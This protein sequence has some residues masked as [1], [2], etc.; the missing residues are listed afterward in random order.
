VLDKSRL[1]KDTH[2]IGLMKRAATI[3]AHAHARAMRFAKPGAWEHEVEAE[4]LHEFRKHGSEYPAYTSIVATGANA[5][6]LHYISNNAQLQDGDLMLIDAGCELGGYASD[7][8]RCF[9]VNGKFSGPQRDLYELVLAA[10]AAAIAKT[11]PGIAYDVPHEAAVKVLAR[12]M[13]DLK[14]LRGSLDSVLKL[15]D[16][17][18][19]SYRRFYM[20]R[21]GHWL[22]MDVHDAGAY[23]TGDKWNKLEVGN[24]VTIEPGIYV[25]PAA[26]VPKA[27]WNIGIRIEDD[28]LLVPGGNTLITHQA[29]KTIQAIEEVMRSGR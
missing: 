16:K 29:P 10:Q 13:L 21:T 18:E 27:F 3:S 9:P 17:G 5:C 14:L 24:V 11:K 7:I 8:T 12:G 4:L 1:V 20:H 23:K 2:E 6:V 19:A 22:G 28:A 25:R 26:D 15:D